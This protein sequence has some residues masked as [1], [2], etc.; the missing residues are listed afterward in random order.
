LKKILLLYCLIFVGYNLFAQKISRDSLL[1][2]QPIR[3]IYKTNPLAVLVG[4]FF[5]S[6]EYKLKREVVIDKQHTW[7]AGFSYLD[8]NIGLAVVEKM[9]RNRGMISNMGFMVKGFKAEL[10]AKYY[11]SIGFGKYAGIAPHGFFLAPRVAYTTLLYAT[12]NLYQKGSYYRASNFSVNF[13]G[14]FQF[15][16]F[17]YMTIEFTG[18][19]GI[20]Q[21]N[22][23][24]TKNHKTSQ[25]SSKPLPAIPGRFNLVLG[26]SIGIPLY[27]K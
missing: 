20:K 26:T 7:E 11:P 15:L 19:M 1:K 16:F 6:A 27:R 25:V 24:L 8:K 21:L 3:V 13:I 17:K 22:L 18:G 9:A 2:I 14:G 10:S 4:P 5:I 12:N 23:Y